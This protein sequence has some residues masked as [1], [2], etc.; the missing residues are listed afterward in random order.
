MTIIHKIIL[1]TCTETVVQKHYPDTVEWHKKSASSDNDYAQCNKT[2]FY[3]FGYRVENKILKTP[4]IWRKK[5]YIKVFD[6]FYKDVDLNNK[7][8]CNS[9][10][11]T[12]ELAYG[13]ELK[14]NHAGSD[15]LEETKVL[16]YANDITEST[17]TIRFKPQNISFV[18]IIK[19]H[20]ELCPSTSMVRTLQYTAYDV[21]VQTKTW[22]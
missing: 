18:L 6:Y 20:N 1:T 17:K 12:Y 4:S 22:F 14:N 2:M 9:I 10:I 11:N 19:V 7:G 3:Y 16:F 21:P 13:V 15:H 8:S 5:D